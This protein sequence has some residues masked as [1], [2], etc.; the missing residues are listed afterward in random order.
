VLGFF[1]IALPFYLITVAESNPSTDSALASVLVSPV[2]LFVIP[3]SAIFLRDERLTPA[4]IAGVVI[5]L[6]GVAI[7]VGFDPASLA[8]NDF[9]SEMLLV[10]AAISYAVGAVYARR[11]MTGYRPMITALFEVTTALV[12]IGVLAFVFERPLQ[13]PITFNSV[14][15][16]V[17]LGLLG[18]GLAFIFNFRLINNWGATRTSTV[19]YLMPVFGIILGAL[20]LAEEV[21][22]TRVFG[23]ALVI[24]GIA[25]VNV[26]RDA[27][28]G[29]WASMRGREPGSTATTADIVTEVVSEQR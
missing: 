9:G 6:V 25:L 17:W 21:T 24:G 14:V 5:G 27:L 20:V 16:V 15:A 8:R 22:L 12:M 28:A 3:M 26:K 10:A 18:S 19:A 23:T 29:K 11:Y 7:L 1:G 13:A 2:P 4:R